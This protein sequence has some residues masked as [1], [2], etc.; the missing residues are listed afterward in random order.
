MTD[1]HRPVLI[2]KVR[3]VV[4]QVSVRDPDTATNQLRALIATYGAAPVTDALKAL[5][6]ASIDQARHEIVTADALNMHWSPTAPTRG[7][8]ATAPRPRSP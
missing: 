5:A 6:T 1:D 7:S 3:P 2:D 8:A 4:D